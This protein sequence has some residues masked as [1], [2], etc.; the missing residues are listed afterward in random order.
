MQRIMDSLPDPI[1]ASL[2]LGTAYTL[3][4][5]S[6]NEASTSVDNNFLTVNDKINVVLI[7]C[8]KCFKMNS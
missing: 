7:P 2:Q 4:A 1:M 3:S 6:P 5:F 8:F